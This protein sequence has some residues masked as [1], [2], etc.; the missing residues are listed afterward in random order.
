MEPK[1][2][3]SDLKRQALELIQAGRMP[4]FRDLLSVIASTREKYGP[5]LEEARSP[6]RD[7]DEIGENEWRLL[8]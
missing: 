3:P 6:K 2:K 4:A 5:Q 1:I 7:W 8:L